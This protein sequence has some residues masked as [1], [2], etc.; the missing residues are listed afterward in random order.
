[1]ADFDTL[2]RN[3]TIVDGTGSPRHQADIGLRDGRIAAVGDLSSKSSDRVLDIRGQIVAPG[4]IDIH[5]HYDAQVF[6]DPTLSPS[7][8]HGVTTV[9]GGNCGFS[10]APLSPDAGDYLTRMLARVEG[11][12][13]ESLQQ[14]VPWNWTSF[15]EYLESFEEDLAINAGFM[16]GHS[17]LRRVVMGE[18][19]V[20]HEADEQ[21]IAAMVELLHE[22]LRGGG[23]GFSSSVAP[24]HNDGDG[25]PVPSRHAAREE[26]IALAGALREH[27]G[28]SLEFLPGVGPFQ[29]AEQEMMADLSCASQ[30]ALNWNVLVVNSYQPDHPAH[31]LGA[32]DF[33]AERGGR[34]I[35][36]TL[37]QVMS[38]RLN[39]VSGFIFDALPGFAEIIALPLPERI[40][41]LADPAVRADLAERAA[42]P[43]AGAMGFFANWGIY[44]I[45]E[46]FSSATKAHEGRTVAEI[47]Q[48]ENKTTFDAML[49]I[50]VAD[51]L[52]TSFKPDMPG[53]DE[54]SWNLRAKVWQDE[55]TVIGAS[56]AGAHLDMIDTF[57]VSTMLLGPG[58]RE[59][60]LL[61]LE[62]AVHQL[63]DIPGRLYGF[64]DRGRIAEGWHADLVIFDENTIGAGP[65]HTREDLPG[66]AARLYAEAEGISRVIVAGVDILVD[67][68][69]TGAT[70]GQVMRSGIDTA[71]TAL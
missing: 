33:A 31:Q 67:G 13:L 46:A 21:E 50:A 57:A 48:A 61:S 37:P 43:D 23:L 71:G 5:T 9:V 7:S 18:K 28:T 34:V 6:W 62:E 27:E 17:A 64:T 60:K 35:A 47:A 11:M 54:Q 53:D 56:D 51:K 26:L 20:G 24:T 2:L 32:A 25:Q 15:A 65:V 69:P 12:P 10:I 1:M 38:L 3:G 66:G 49:D 36:L 19:A 52:K 29:P 68:E 22:S 70:P 44:R 40:E 8:N 55:R 45:D 14:G 30:R 63:T 39:F 16:V 59:K 58:V 41:K 42:S 4:F